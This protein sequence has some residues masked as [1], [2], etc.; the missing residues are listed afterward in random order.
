MAVKYRHELK[1]EISVGQMESLRS[2]IRPI[3][4]LDQHTNKDGN[5]NIR[6]LY[7]DDYMNTCFYENEDG[8]SPREKFRIRIYNSNYEEIHLELKRK[9]R[10]KTHKDSCLLTK[11]QCDSILNGQSLIYQNDFPPVLKKFYLLQKTKL[12]KPKVIVEYEREPYVY[13]NGNVR[14]TFDTNIR[15]SNKVDNFFEH[16]IASR[17]IMPLGHHLLE[18]KYDEFL[19]DYI[20]R[21]LQIDNLQLTTFSKYYLCRKYNLGGMSRNGIQ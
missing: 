13:K 20:Y 12:L 5:Y 6:S 1:Y 21:S 4:N 9:E 11:Q 10:G 3:M 2:R 18:V 14:V 16:L 8:T 17:P 7:F 15:S 19:P